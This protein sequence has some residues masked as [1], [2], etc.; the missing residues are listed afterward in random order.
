MVSMVL[1]L[2]IT[3]IFS[4]AIQKRILWH[5]EIARTYFN[6]VIHPVSAVPTAMPSLNHKDAVVLKNTPTITPVPTRS[7]HFKTTPVIPSSPTPTAIPDRV[8]L[9]SPDYELQDINNCGPASLT[10]YLRYYGWEG[11]QFAISDVI[12]PIPQDRNV[13][14]EEMDYFVRNYAGWLNTIYRVGGDTQLMKQLLAAGVPVLIEETFHF[15]ENYWPNDDLWAGHYLLLTGYDEAL[16]AFLTQDSFKGPDRWLDE[17]LLDQQWQAF[18]R[19][20]MLVYLPE[21]ET[22]IQNI[23]ADNW[24]KDNNRQNA[25]RIAENETINDPENAFAWFNLG[26][27]LVYFG[28]YQEAAEAYDQARSIGWPQRMLRYQFG[29]FFA[30]FHTQRNEDLH[31]LLDYALDRTPNSEEALLWQGWLLYREGDTNAAMQSFQA[32]LEARPDYPDA[33]YAI[34][35]ISNN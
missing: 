32:A 19:V 25:M 8:I 20:Y 7:P 21:Q 33:L 30:Y 28:Q 31:A 10:M 34:D 11:D 17:S 16:K 26:S 1:V 12:K 14:I 2:G 6:G 3:L 18:N 9:N 23:L 35:F 27:N 4:P 24:D 15:E 29:P 13:N 22:I 5:Y